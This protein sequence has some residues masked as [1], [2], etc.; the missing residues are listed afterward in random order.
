M[1]IAWFSPLRSDAGGETSLSAYCTELLLPELSR[2]AP[3][4]ISFEIFHDGFSSHA[5]YPTYHYL[6]AF[7]R[8]RDNPFDLF[9]YQV[10]DARSARFN[11]F[12][13]GLYPGLTLFHDVLINEEGPVPLFVSPWEHTV[14]KFNDLSKA[15]P[16]RDAIF[17]KE[18]PFA[19]R[20]C[21][22]AGVPVFT[23][24]RARNEY[25][26]L[27]R[28]RLVDSPDYFLPLPVDVA[29]QP[30]REASERGSYVVGFCGTPWMQ[31]RAHLFLPSVRDAGVKLIWLIES[32]EKSAA[33]ALLKEFAIS[34]VE[35][36]EGRSPYQW[37]KL[38]PQIHA[39][40][41]PLFSAFGQ[42][43]IYLAMSLA[44]GL[45]TITST[46]GATEYLPDAVSFRVQ[47][48]ASEQ[49]EYREILAALRQGTRS[50]RSSIASYAAELHD[51][52]I[53]AQELFSVI[54]AARRI[55]QPAMKQFDAMLYDAR[56]AL[57][58]EALD[59]VATLPREIQ[60][61]ITAPFEELGWKV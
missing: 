18:G 23:S 34:D 57:H 3:Q 27:S 20:E 48:G 11:R 5:G 2:S 46:Y 37:Q 1:R 59:G 36:I 21:A 26:R 28:A 43:G 44:A 24:E 13:L 9:V 25:R 6:R 22:L 35:L 32:H 50:P 52:R 41:H 19:F 58:R 51:V 10:E 16:S 30:A 42:P 8:H 4:Q 7:E 17:E 12:S 33:E 54:N 49:F 15:W 29:H 55:V 45:P 60:S 56:R 53:V 61:S 31:D 47:P 39:A 14:A 38:L 40:A